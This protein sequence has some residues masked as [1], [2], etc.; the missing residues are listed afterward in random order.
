QP[1][2]IFQR[3]FLKPLAFT[4]LT[5]PAWLLAGRDVRTTITGSTLLFLVALLFFNSRWGRTAEEVVADWL[6]GHWRYLRLDI[7]PALV[8]LI[9]DLFRRLLEDLDRLLYTVDE[10]LRFRQGDS[11]LRFVAKLVLSP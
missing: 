4:A 7:F 2:R 5:A 1:F 9:L 8:R 6:L 3:H 11:R 10:W